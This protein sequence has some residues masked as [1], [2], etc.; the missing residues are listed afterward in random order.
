MKKFRKDTGTKSALPSGRPTDFGNWPWR[1]CRTPEK[2][3]STDPKEAKV[4]YSQEKIA[5]AEFESH[6]A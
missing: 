1:G 4:L 5:E 2:E 6:N 3:G